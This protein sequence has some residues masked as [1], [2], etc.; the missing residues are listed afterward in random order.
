MVGTPRVA[1]VFGGSAPV[2]LNRGG[3]NTTVG[4]IEDTSNRATSL[5]FTATLWQFP[6]NVST[7]V[8]DWTK[9]PSLVAP[10]SGPSMLMVWLAS[11]GS[12][13]RFSTYSGAVWAPAANITNALS[14]DPAALLPLAGGEVL[15]AFRGT[16]GKAYVASYLAGSW[17]L[18]SLVAGG[19]T[20]VGPPALAK[21]Q[22]G[23]VAELAYVGTD[24]AAYH[25]RLAASRTWTAPVQVATSVDFVSIASGP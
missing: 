23:M 20:I 2:I 15:M 12:Q 22:G 24:G 17:G 10:T 7:E 5:D 21:G 19:V 14:F 6:V 25:V 18:P 8:T 11:V 4:Y 3:G 1:Q 16:D 13:Y 9:S